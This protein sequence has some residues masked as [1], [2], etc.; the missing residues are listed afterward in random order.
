MGF[1]HRREMAQEIAVVAR[2]FYNVVRREFIAVT[3]GAFGGVFCPCIGVGRKINII[4]EQFDG[5]YE[6]GDLQQPTFGA[7]GEAQREERLRL[8]EVFG[9]KE[10]IGER[11]F[12]EIEN[13][14]AGARGA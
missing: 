11:L 7:H 3:L 5:R 10:I 14:F 12:A 4:A 1:L 8:S 2:D 6:V 13:Q 9:R